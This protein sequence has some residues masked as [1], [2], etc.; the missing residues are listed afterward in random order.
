MFEGYSLLFLLVAIEAEQIP[1][2]N[3]QVSIFGGM[4]MMTG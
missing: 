3:E 2:S 4:G 1:S